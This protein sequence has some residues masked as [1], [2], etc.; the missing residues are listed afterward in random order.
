MGCNGEEGGE[1]L[2]SCELERVVTCTYQSL[3][4]NLSQSP[5]HC[6]RNSHSLCHRGERKGKLTTP[7]PQ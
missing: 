5:Q 1:R 6:H 7:G 2:I 3:D 4:V